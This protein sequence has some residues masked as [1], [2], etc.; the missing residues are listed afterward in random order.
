MNI[1][2]HTAT[3]YSGAGTAAP[4]TTRSAGIASA[5]LDHVDAAA[6]TAGGHGVRVPRS[7]RTGPP[8]TRDPGAAQS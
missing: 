3:T 8:R 1:L 6:R 4:R 7:A 5:A 2:T